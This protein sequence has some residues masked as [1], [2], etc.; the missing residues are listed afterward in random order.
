MPHVI[1]ECSE[2]LA[3]I[4]SLDDVVR[5]L[6]EAA[7]ATGVFP[8]GGLRTRVHV[9]QQYRI[10]DGDP[11]HVF[12]HVQLRIGKGRDVATRKRASEQMF[13]ALREAMALATAATTVALS[14]E[15]VE[16]DSDTGHNYNTIHEY[17]EGRPAA[18]RA[19]G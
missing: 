16:I 6:H 19:G 17:L 1:I 8:L 11:R 10:A 15:I 2:N 14:L 5:R 4:V 12:M 7:L 18:R 13:T 9:A 3:Q